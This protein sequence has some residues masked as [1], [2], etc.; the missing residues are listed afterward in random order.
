AA[1]LVITQRA[2]P[3]QRSAVPR[4]REYPTLAEVGGL[5]LHSIFLDALE[6]DVE[7]LER[8]NRV[9]AGL[10]A[11]VPAP[12]GLRPVRLLVGRPSRDL[13]ELAAG[14]GARLPPMVRWGVRGV[15]GGRA[16]AVALLS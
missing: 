1:L 13:G 15:G 11:G 7:R 4:L 9:L 16:A 5:L 6:A 3:G 8:L 2:E 10:P 12:D 14:Y